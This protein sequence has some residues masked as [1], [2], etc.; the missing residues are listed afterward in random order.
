MVA[1]AP[2]KRSLS[3]QYSANKTILHTETKGTKNYRLLPLRDLRFLLFRDSVYGVLSNSLAG[4]ISSAA[5]LVSAAR[6][7]TPAR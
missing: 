3:P 4:I 7:S 1:T 5:G 6:F 2:G